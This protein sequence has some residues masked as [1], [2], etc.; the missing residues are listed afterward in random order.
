MKYCS[1]KMA[2][3]AERRLNIERAALATKSRRDHRPQSSGRTCGIDP[4]AEQGCT[5]VTRLDRR[6]TL[7]PL[8]IFFRSDTH[9]ALKQPQQVP[10]NLA[11]RSVR[12]LDSHENQRVL[13]TL[14]T[15]ASGP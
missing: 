9:R 2:S 10:L 1:I 3:T 4:N 8:T 6:R 5:N 11:R 13:A 15:Y 14:R 12:K 7:S